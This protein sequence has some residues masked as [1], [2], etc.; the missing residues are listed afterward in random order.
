M[1]S[2]HQTLFSSIHYIFTNVSTYNGANINND[3]RRNDISEILQERINISDQ[4]L[5][6]AQARKHTLN[7]HRM[8]SALFHVLC[9]IK[10]KTGTKGAQKSFATIVDLYLKM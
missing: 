5:D 3:S 8:K 10:E 2:F 1:P 7:C 6:E 9:E 4:S